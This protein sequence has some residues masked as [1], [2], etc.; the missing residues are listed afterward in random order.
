[1]NASQQNIPSRIVDLFDDYRN[2]FIDALL[3]QQ[4]VQHPT[5]AQIGLAIAALIDYRAHHDFSPEQ[6]D[7][8]LEQLAAMNLLR[9]QLARSD[10]QPLCPTADR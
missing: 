10:E 9:S 1:M 2:G 7:K 3:Y 5:S 6:A 4:G 8:R